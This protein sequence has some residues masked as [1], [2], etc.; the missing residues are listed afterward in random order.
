ML[1]LWSH[2]RGSHGQNTSWTASFTSWAEGH[3]GGASRRSASALD[4][5]PPAAMPKQ[6][7]STPI[8]TRSRPRMEYAS[9]TAAPNPPRK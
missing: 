9:L 7:H 3:A 2:V 8:G 4:N 6:L 1:V 5:A